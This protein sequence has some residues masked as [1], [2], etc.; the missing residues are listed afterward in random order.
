MK[1]A[2]FESDVIKA[3]NDQ[4]LGKVTSLFFA[5]LVFFSTTATLP[6]LN[7]LTLPG[8][9]RNNGLVLTG[10]TFLSILVVE[11]SNLKLNRFFGAFA[12]FLI[13]GLVTSIGMAILLTG[14]VD[15]IAG[16]TPLDSI[17][18]GLIWLLFNGIAILVISYCYS[19][20]TPSFLNR[21]LDIFLL[22][23]LIVS[24]VQALAMLGIPGFSAVFEL[25]N[26]GDWLSTFKSVSFGRLVGVCS[27]PSAM[28]MTLGLLCLPYCYSRF[29]HGG[30]IRYGISLL[31]LLVF[32]LMTKSTTVYVTVAFFVVGS[33][34]VSSGTLKS[35][36]LLAALTVVIAIACIAFLIVLVT[37]GDL[38]SKEMSDVLESVLGKIGDVSNQSTAYRNST[39]INDLEIF[40]DYPLFG[41]GDGNQGYF[42]SQNI[43]SWVISSG[44][45]EVLDALSGSIGVLN[46]G[47]FIPSLVSG[48]GFLGCML[49]GSWICFCIRRAVIRKKE[50]GCYYDMFLISAFACIPVCWM[51]TSFQGAPIAV[52]LVFCLPA[53]GE[54]E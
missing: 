46:G 43:P 18:S 23:V 20:C 22:F 21:I 25:L 34:L 15:T 42:Y 53:L 24:A 30:G 11:K 38:V 6:L 29:V 44:S 28:S 49:F 41:V 33:F 37:G 9:V 45:T 1:G 4:R 26:V 16:E 35:K 51:A 2:H 27:E 7:S 17:L 19:R 5:L 52:F 10:L 48:Y 36:G 40:K 13:A 14:E 31:L 12:P 50:L 32:A 8:F 3:R 39:I 54:G 47:A